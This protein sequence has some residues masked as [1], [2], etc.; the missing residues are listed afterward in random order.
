MQGDAVNT[1]ATGGDRIDI[2]LHDVAAGV[3]AGQQLVAVAIG[4][5][6]AKL[7]GDD[8]AIDRQIVDVAGGKIAAAAKAVVPPIERGRQHMQ[9]QL[10]AVGIGGLLEDGHMLAGHLV[11]VGLR[12]VVQIDHYHPGADKAGVEVD[13]GIGNVLAL[14]AR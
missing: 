12:V 2:D 9:L 11:V 5:L 4:G 14:D 13:V 7:G 8:G 6:V 1:T 10:V 3:E